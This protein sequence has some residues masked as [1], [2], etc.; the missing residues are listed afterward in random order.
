MYVFLCEDSPEGIF[1]PVSTMPGRAALDT[2]IFPCRSTPEK[3][4]MI[5]SALTGIS[6]R[7]YKKVRK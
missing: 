5:C 2:T 3:R 7:I 1:L 4:T 6:H